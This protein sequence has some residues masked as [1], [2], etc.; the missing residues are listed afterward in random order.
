MVQQRA[1]ILVSTLWA[2]SLWTIGYLVAPTLF[3]ILEDKS[4]AGTIAGRLFRIEAW[5]SIACGVLLLALVWAKGPAY[6]AWT[7]KRITLLIGA[8][9]ACTLVGYFGL[10]PQMA[11]LREAASGADAIAEAAKARFG[12]LHGISSALYMLQSLIAV[13]LLFRLQVQQPA[14]GGSS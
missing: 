10:Q 11:Q 6:D 7:R 13:P 14:Q 5:L 2:G 12:M 8:M 3:T 1:R 4:L 9:L